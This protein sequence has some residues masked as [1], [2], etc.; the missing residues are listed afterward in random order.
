MKAKKMKCKLCGREFKN[1]FALKIHIGRLHGSKSK[2]AKARAVKPAAKAA[3]TCSICGRSFGMPAHL[4]RHV[5]ASHARGRRNVP[6]GNARPAARHAPARA[7]RG[8]SASAG[9]RVLALTVDQLVDLKNALD[10]RLA[11]IAQQLRKA[12]IE[13]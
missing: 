4:A 5:S 1:D 13:V 12:K 7:V 2:A 3:M 8:P 11:A 9:A 10:A 6:P